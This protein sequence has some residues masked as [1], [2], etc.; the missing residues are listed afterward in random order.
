MTPIFIP[1]TLSFTSLTVV[2]KRATVGEYAHKHSSMA[3]SNVNLFSFVA[4]DASSVIRLD[5]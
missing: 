5:N 1:L 4:V 2:G 3:S